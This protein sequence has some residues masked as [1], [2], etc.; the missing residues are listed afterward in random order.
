MKIYIPIPK[1][2]FEKLKLMLRDKLIEKLVKTFVIITIGFAAI[3]IWKWPYLP[4]EIPLFYSLPR[5]SEQLAKSFFIF[6]L[7]IFS[8]V[9]FFI[10]FL[11]AS[12]FYEKE[13]L[14]S[15]FL[16]IASIVNSLLLFIAF[17]RIIFLIT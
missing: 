10:N 14:A 15:I 12:I 8:L 16:L 9:F 2:K 4:P 11:L 7:P 5:G 6:L 17:S 13:K 3:G 1:Y